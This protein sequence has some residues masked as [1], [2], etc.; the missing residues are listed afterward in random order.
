M[1]LLISANTHAP[2][3]MIAERGAEWILE[4]ARTALQAAG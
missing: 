2:T 1:P 3:I 4:D